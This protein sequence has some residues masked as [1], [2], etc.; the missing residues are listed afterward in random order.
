MFVVVLARPFADILMLQSIVSCGMIT[1]TE[2]GCSMCG[3]LQRVLFDQQLQTAM[4]QATKAETASASYQEQLKGEQQRN[5]SWLLM[6]KPC[7][8][9]HSVRYQAGFTAVL[10]SHKAHTCACCAVICFVCMCR[11][12]HD[13]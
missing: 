3:L 1:A 5:Q 4:L 12:M 6:L 9:K 7:S 11:C 8:N 10:T 13:A 2:H